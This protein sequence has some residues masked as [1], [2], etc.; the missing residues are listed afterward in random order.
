MTSPEPTT[1]APPP[2]WVCGEPKRTNA[3]LLKGQNILACPGCGLLHRWPLPDPRDVVQ[4]LRRE[5]TIFPDLIEQQRRGKDKLR[6]WQLERVEELSPRGKLLDVGSGYGLF[7][8]KARQAGWETEGVELSYPEWRY[9]TETFHLDVRQETLEEARFPSDHFD[10]VTLW[11]VAELLTDPWSVF[12]EIRRVLKPGGWLWMRGN[13]ARF[14]LPVLRLEKRPPVS[15]TRARPGIFHLFGFTETTLTRSLRQAGLQNEASFPSPTTAGDPYGLGGSLGTTGVRL[16]KIAVEAISQTAYALTAGRRV[17]SSN[18]ITRAQKPFPRPLVF[19]LITRLDRGGSSENVV[20]S[21]EEMAPT[22]FNSVLACGK[23][24]FPTEALK[25]KPLLIPTLRREISPRQD[26][27]AFRKIH[28]VLKAYRPEILHTHSSKAGILGR[29]AG[30]FAGVPHIV[31][32]PHGHV[33]Y[34]YFGRVKSFLYAL[35]EGFSAS[36]AERLVAL[37]EGEKTESLRWGMGRAAQW[38]VINSGVSLEKNW[39]DRRNELRHNLRLELKIPEEAIVIGMIGRLEPVKGPQTL[40]EAAES[41]L[42]PSNGTIPPFYFLFVGDGPEKDALSQRRSRLRDPERIILTGHRSPAAPFLAVMDIYVQPSL[43]EGMGKALVQAQAMG[44]PVIASRV[45]GIPDVVLDGETGVLVPPGD[46]TALAVAVDA[47]A[48]NP[49]KRK[50][51][52]ERGA[53]WVF[54]EADGHPRFSVPRM[55]ALLQ[56]LY[57]ELLAK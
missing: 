50:T 8:E 6:A 36:A 17:F 15:W 12:R 51:L 14:H 25:R 1:S 4:G 54:E 56:K 28:R 52:G 35:L 11:E 31:H 47:L 9:S 57:E 26:F 55:I 39:L 18:I 33:F 43:N 49:A 37:T 45:C 29:W 10:V 44:L 38:R 23:T 5:R 22:L 34:G 16:G 3:L 41:L 40:A 21:A 42:A 48:N 46:A 7:L 13:N 24:D 32:T 19:H 2:C 27:I 30:V 53:R 20:H